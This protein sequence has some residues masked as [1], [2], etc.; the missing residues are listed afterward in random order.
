MQPELPASDL[1]LRLL[2]KFIFKQYNPTIFSDIFKSQ[3][4][5]LSWRLSILPQALLRQLKAELSLQPFWYPQ[6]E[7]PENEAVS[8]T[9]RWE[10]RSLPP[11]L[12]PVSPRASCM[13]PGDCRLMHFSSLQSCALHQ[14]HGLCRNTLK[15]R[16]E[17]LQQLPTF[18]PLG[19]HRCYTSNY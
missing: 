8:W 15:I 19:C 4:W 9:C 13:L 3:V 1:F 16:T 5:S 10:K 14:C 11:E 17:H 12:T 6:G 7:L 18:E 2:M